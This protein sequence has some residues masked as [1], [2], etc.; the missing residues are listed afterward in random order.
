MWVPDRRLRTQDGSITHVFVPD[1][2]LLMHG[3]LWV[4][5]S[6]CGAPP[7]AEALCSF[8]SGMP[9]WTQPPV[10]CSRASAGLATGSVDA[11]CH[12]CFALQ[13]CLR[14]MRH[15]QL[16]LYAS[17]G[18]L[19]PSANAFNQRDARP[20]RS[21]LDAWRRK[22]L[23]QHVESLQAKELAAAARSV[24]A[25]PAPAAGRAEREQAAATMAAARE[26][27]SDMR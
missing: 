5:G 17:D 14:R 21:Q 6:E 26:Q 10:M 16:L 7:A 11:I 4:R 23:Q 27:H 25:R 3:S 15:T 9:F 19:L 1:A 18:H 24:G 12:A 20:T 8:P 13:A 22:A 2:S